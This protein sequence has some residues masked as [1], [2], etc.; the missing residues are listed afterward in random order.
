MADNW[1]VGDVAK[2]VDVRDIRL[3]FRRPAQGGRYLKLGMLYPVNGVATNECG[4]LT[5]D[6]SAKWGWKLACRFVK[7][8]PLEEEAALRQAQDERIG[9]AA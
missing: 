2:C 6:V 8:P 3:P 1:Q 5:L 7:V 4:D 9:V